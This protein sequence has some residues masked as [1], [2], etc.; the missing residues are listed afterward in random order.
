MR[1]D[2]IVPYRERPQ[3]LSALLAY[4]ETHRPS[5]L[6][7]VLSE[8]GARASAE[9]VAA[10][11]DWVTYLFAREDGP[12]NKSKALNSGLAAVD[13]DFVMPY[14][15]DLLPVGESL[16]RHLT[17]TRAPGFV[18][19]GFRLMSDSPTAPRDIRLA[20]RAAELPSEL[21][22]I[23]ARNMLVKGWRFGI[24]PL[25]R[26]DRI[27]A[28]GGWSEAYVGWGGED[29]DLLDRYLVAGQMFCLS[30]DIVYLHLSHEPVEGWN[31]QNLVSA[32]AKRF[33]GDR[34]SPREI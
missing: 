14:D 4:L 30:P 7:V 9:T 32:N 28:I 3:H 25:L 33:W 19:A 18:V 31:D 26:R 5:G 24:N 27:E 16:D 15:V 21:D 34:V 11:F 22:S 29:A 23:S 1:V 12:F 17:A 2:L 6:R 10:R 13:A 8:R 20:A